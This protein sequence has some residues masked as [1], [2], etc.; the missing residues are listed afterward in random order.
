[1]A[2]M[3]PRAQ[4]GLRGTPAARPVE[5]GRPAMKRSHVV[6]LAAIGFVAVAGGVGAS[7]MR[8]PAALPE[9]AE[10]V[11]ALDAKPQQEGQAQQRTGGGVMI[12]PVVLPRAAPAPGTFSSAPA[13]AAAPPA[14]APPRPAATPDQPQRGGFGETA[15]AHGASGGSSAVAS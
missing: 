14:A 9:T 8:G 3:A 15:K 11:A 1:M 13:P 4:F 12:V 2:A 7:L 5:A 10:P 6:A